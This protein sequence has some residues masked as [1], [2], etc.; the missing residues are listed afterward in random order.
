M[1]KGK[2][3]A[4]LFEL[5]GKSR[6]VDRTRGSFMA[7]RWLEW[8]H[9]GERVSEDVA[10]ELPTARVAKPNAVS[11]QTVEVVTAA[12]DGGQTAT[13]AI[14]QYLSNAV[15]WDHRRLRIDLSANACVLIAAVLFMFL[16]IVFMVGKQ[17][18]RAQM[19]GRINL[20]ATDGLELQEIRAGALKPEV[21]SRDQGPIS[22][23]RPAPATS[24]DLQEAP[25]RDKG[26]NYL[27]IESFKDSLKAYSCRDYLAD[28]DVAATVDKSGEW[29]QV[30]GLDGFSSPNSRAAA[31]YRDKVRMLGNNHARRAGGNKNFST[32]HFAKEK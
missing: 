12:P 17:A 21:L 16:I 27:V 25:S 26:L 23:G 29:W 24:R 20:A 9:R 15:Q 18:G 11:L 4:T 2:Q 10:E 13:Q 14:R 28:N 1:A 6:G 32:T 22:T 19:A 7:P 30:K 3:T 31:A 8:V 5:V